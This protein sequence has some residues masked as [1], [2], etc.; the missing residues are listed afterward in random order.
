VCIDL[1]SAHWLSVRIASGEAGDLRAKLTKILRH[2]ESDEK[3]LMAFTAASG[4]SNWD[5]HGMK[6]FW[7]DPNVDFNLCG[8]RVV[9]P[10]WQ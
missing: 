5:H 6:F 9:P 1:E 2:L 8:V 4:L 3:V 10:H 7:K